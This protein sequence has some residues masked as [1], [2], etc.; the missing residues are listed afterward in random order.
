MPT[1][2]SQTRQRA[3]GP[4]LR[5]DQRLVLNQYMLLR[6]FGAGTFEEL[7][8]EMKDPAFEGWDENNIS[9]FCHSLLNGRYLERSELDEDT[10]LQYDRNIARHTRVIQGRRPEKIHWK[11]FQYFA[12][13]FTE[14]YLDRYFRD[15]DGLLEGLNNHVELF[16]RD[17]DDADRVNLYRREDLSKLAYWK[18]TGSGKTLIMH[19]NILQYLDY[20]ALHQRNEELNRIILLTPN[21]GLSRQHLEEFHLSGLEAR[22]FDK[23]GTIP[24]EKLWGRVKQGTVEII[25]IHK[26]KEEAGQKTVAIEAF[27]GNNLVLVDEGHRGSSG[28]DWKSRRDRLCQNGFSFEY[29]ATFGQAMKAS[30]KKELIQE[31]ARCILIDYSYKFFY[32]DGFGKNYHILNLPDDSDAD[33]KNLYLT[34]CLLSF[35]Q[36]QKIF[37]EQQRALVPFNLEKPLWVFVGSK[38]TA[39]RTENRRKVSDVVDILLFLSDFVRD[40]GRSIAALDLLLSG[41]P[42]LLNRKNEELFANQFTY[43]HRIRL[44][45]RELFQDI[46]ATLFNNNVAGALLHVEN[47]KGSEGEIGLRV[48]DND[49]FGVINVGD[50]RNLLKLC[51]ENGLYVSEKDFSHSLFALLGDR[52]SPINVLIG[53]KKFSEGWNS[54]RVSTMG[55][56]NIGRKEGSEIIQLF[57]RGVRL[58]GYNLSLKRS[59]ALKDIEDRVPGELPLLET[60]NV[61]GVRAD[62]MA[63]FQEYLA[64]EG[65]PA[66]QGTTEMILPVLKNLGKKKLKVIKLQEGVNFKKNG[67]RPTLSTPDSYLQK[68]PVVVNWYPRIESIRSGATGG[69]PFQELQEGKL[70]AGHIAFLDLDALYF[71]LQQLKLEQGWHNLNLERETIYRLLRDSSWYRL[72]IPPHELEFGSF[73]RVRR[74]QEIAGVL[75]KKYCRRFYLAQKAAYEADKLEYTTVEEYEQKLTSAGKEG[76][77]PPAYH[78]YVPETETAFIEQL[79]QLKEA[80]EKG[81]LRDINF[82]SMM[83]VIFMEQHLYQPLLALNHSEIKVTPVQLNRGEKDFVLDLRKYVERHADRF[84]GKELYLLRNQSR[85]RGIGFFELGNFYPDFILWLVDNSKQYINFIDPKGLR[86]LNAMDDP[87]INFYKS[88]KD[89]DS[90][91]DPDVILNS[92]II[93]I[94]PFHRV[95]WRGSITKDDFEACNVF[96]QEDRDEYIGKMFGRIK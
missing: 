49:Y 5:F 92:F 9:W 25:D 45:G 93:S 14:I 8:A 26:L 63:Q 89:I 36:Q 13:L 41:R 47:L 72:Y 75:L 60:L 27:E 6:I 18:A 78:F 62:Y 20:L 83:D 30:G 28:I 17:K 69:S 94:T 66:D 88:I 43:L 65:L 67:P 91:K 7:A 4:A 84:T 58:K 82:S 86:N 21:E 96:F 70:G 52:Q 48:G 56:M 73:D 46:L 40:D 81:D 33:K 1:A 38:V 80:I 23:D 50:E 79:M 77:I 51:E 15:P 22:Y 44:R 64:E 59:S 57:G 2:R 32:R 55:L 31:Y 11:Y 54:W 42:G 95:N 61:F 74:W 90:L 19:V 10:L 53:S 71:E 39:V 85:G 29:S 37:L 24:L 34:A 35:Y 87:K 12:L 76:N 3:A 16:N 68:N